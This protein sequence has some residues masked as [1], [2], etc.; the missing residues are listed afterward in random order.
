MTHTSFGPS[1]DIA[2]SVFGKPVLVGSGY[3]TLAQVVPFH[4]ASSPLASG[5][6]SP[7]ARRRYIGPFRAP[8]P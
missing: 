3:D 5:V 2:L 7:I 8:G 6:L 4:C 1:A